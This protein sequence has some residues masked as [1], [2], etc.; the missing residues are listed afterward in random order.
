MDVSKSTEQQMGVQSFNQV[1]GEYGNRILPDRHPTARY[2]QSVVKRIVEANGL[3]AGPG[4]WETHVVADDKTRNA[5]V[6]PGG[7]IFVFSGILPIAQDSDGLAVILGHEI[8]HQVARHSAERMSGLKV[9]FVLSLALESLGLDAGLS[10]VL[11]N[12]VMTLPNS[13]KSESEADVIGLQLANQACFDVRAARG[14]WQRMNKAEGA[15]GSNVDFLSTH[16]S[17]SKRVDTVT[18]WADKVIQDRPAECGPLEH[19]ADAFRS[20]AR[21]S[22]RW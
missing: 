20:F 17:S 19:Q 15:A 13:R 1:M 10:R 6:L 16:P 11:L 5:F 14:L 3:E 12:L 7:K 18:E 2:V 8:A 4:G 9:L 21:S 22:S